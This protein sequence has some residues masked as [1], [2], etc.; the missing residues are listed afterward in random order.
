MLPSFT[1]AN[2]IEIVNFSFHYVFRTLD[3]NISWILR[4][5]TPGR[6]ISLF[7]A[8]A[9][10]TFQIIFKR[11]FGDLD[12]TRSDKLDTRENALDTIHSW[13]R[14]ERSQKMARS[15]WPGTIHFYFPS[16]GIAQT[17][18]IIENMYCSAMLQSDVAHTFWATTMMRESNTRAAFFLSI[19][20]STGQEA[21]L[22]AIKDAAC[23]RTLTRSHRWHFN[24]FDDCV[25]R[26][27]LSPPAFRLS[28]YVYYIRV[29]ETF[30]VSSPVSKFHRNLHFWFFRR[31]ND[32]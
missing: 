14:F 23:D 4:V 31:L 16:S 2:W 20:L 6:A 12:T 26:F 25:A 22:E 8:K 13:P 32:L 29:A 5:E 10:S 24:C 30:P 27:T 15:V 18:A 28:T 1:L 7:I 9:I 19:S 11:L 21:K 3:Q 17:D